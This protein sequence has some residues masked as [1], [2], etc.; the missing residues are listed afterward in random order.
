METMQAQK[1]INLDQINEMLANGGELTEEQE[2]FIQLLKNLGF[3]ES[4]VENINGKE[5]EQ[6]KEI[7]EATFNSARNAEDLTE[8]IE[9]WEN[10]YDWMYNQNEKINAVIREREK[11]ERKYQHMLE[12]SKN[13]VSDLV[14]LRN[15]NLASLQEESKLLTEQIT[16]AKEE[17]D[18]IFAENEY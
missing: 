10:P 5:I 16:K 14:I 8:E 9:K 17:I 6:F 4:T 7:E 2:N 13:T 3:I 1:N 11:L 15:Q 12:S 18:N